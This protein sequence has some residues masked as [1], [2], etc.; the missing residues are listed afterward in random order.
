MRPI[1]GIT[2]SNQPGER[3]MLFKDYYVE[4]VQRAGGLPI[5][6]PPTRME[7]ELDQYLEL[8]QALLFTGG[9]DFDPALW[10]EYLSPCCG[11]IDPQ[12]D[13]FE[14]GLAHRA[15]QAQRPTLGICRGCQLLNVAAGGSLRQHIRSPQ[16]H[17]QKAPRDHPIHAIFIEAGSRLAGIMQSEQIWVNS[18]HH[19]AV[20]R[21]G[22]GFAIT[23]MAED[24]TVEAIEKAGTGFCVGVQWHPECLGD[25][26]SARLFAGLVASAA[27]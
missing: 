27:I 26:Y 4:A 1:V 15:L 14:L 13:R 22:E 10:G 6:L 21:L 7:S 2:G 23:A 5:L 9:G 19:Q 16:G 17:N 24:G 20:K 25:R 11:E 18:F 12:R 3:V 8:C